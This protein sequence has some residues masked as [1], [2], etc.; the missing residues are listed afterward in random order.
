MAQAVQH[1]EADKKKWTKGEFKKW[2]SEH[3][4][5][6]ELEADDTKPNFWVSV[7]EFS[8]SQCK[9]G[10]FMNLTE[11]TPDGIHLVSCDRQGRRSEDDASPKVLRVHY[12]HVLE[13]AVSTSW[14]ILPEKLDAVMAFLNIKAAGGD[15]PEEDIRALVAAQRRPLPGP[16]AVA[17]LPLFGMVTHRASSLMA[18]S[19]ATSTERFAERFRQLV[20][21][22]AVAAIVIDVDSPGGTV[23]GVDELSA[24]IHAAR[25]AKPVTAVAN[26]LMASAAYWVGSAAGEVVA[27]PSAEIGSIGVLGIH[28]ETSR[29][30]ESLGV[31]RTIVRAGKH[32]AEANPF[33]PLS[34]EAREH[35]QQRVDEFYDMFVRRVAKNRGVPVGNVRGGFGQGRLLGA[36]EAVAEGLIDRVATMEDVL[37]GLVR[38]LGGQDIGHANVDGQELAA[39]EPFEEAPR[40]DYAAEQ[41]LLRKRLDLLD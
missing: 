37:R 28:T 20:T 3:K 35:I 23:N 27:I 30:D 7:P 40:S 21:D 2:L 34:E 32:K 10:S 4:F 18:A 22:P 36:R 15:I 26:S 16:G 29:R 31:T 1:V 33:E 9:P 11:T 41:E 24:E 5:K 17:V 14:A 38:Q 19:G 39:A 6:S 12:P 25:R 13:A 8:S